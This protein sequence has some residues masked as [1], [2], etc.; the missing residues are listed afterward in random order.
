MAAWQPS[1]GKTHVSSRVSTRFIKAYEQ[2]RSGGVSAS[3][4]PRVAVRENETVHAVSVMQM[5]SHAL[6]RRYSAWT[7]W[8]WGLAEHTILL[9]L[10]GS[11][12]YVLGQAAFFWQSDNPATRGCC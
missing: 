7:S 4:K 5:V 11:A 9:P 12:L 2:S 10:R 6:L 3:K 1:P 8:N